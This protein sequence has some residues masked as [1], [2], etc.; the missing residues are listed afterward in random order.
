MGQIL[1][2]ITGSD[3]K[4]SDFQKILKKWAKKYQIWIILWITV[5][6]SVNFGLVSYGQRFFMWK[7]VISLLI[8]IVSSCGSDERGASIC[9]ASYQN[10]NF[11]IKES[12]K[13]I[14]YSTV[15]EVHESGGGVRVIELDDDVPMAMPRLAIWNEWVFAVNGD[16]IW[17]G[18]NKNT[19]D[20]FGE[21]QWSKLPMT[22]L[23]EDSVILA[24]SAISGRE[25]HKPS[26]W[27]VN[28]K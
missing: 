18:Y 15:F 12:K 13:M 8:L 6:T 7:Y 22:K 10:Y 16:T 19:K 2:I 26:G 14:G 17:G 24:S 4:C 21:H 5:A 9:E 1:I 27:D 20:I 28:Q 25:I 23:P 3:R 11:R